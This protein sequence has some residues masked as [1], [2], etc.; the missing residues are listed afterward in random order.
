MARKIGLM[1]ALATRLLLLFFLSFILG[2]TTEVF[3]LTRLG[4]PSEWLVALKGPL[5]GRSVTRRST[6]SPGET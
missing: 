6:R 4:I 2:L 3:S 1:V 5:K